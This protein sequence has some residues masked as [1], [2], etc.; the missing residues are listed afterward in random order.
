MADL[1][2]SIKKGGPIG[3]V[4]AIILGSVFAV[5]GGYVNDKDDPGGETNHGITKAVAIKNGYVGP[6]ISMPKETAGEIYYKNY[7][8]GPGFEPMINISPAVT[9]ELVDSGVNM[10][11]P[12]P[13]R[14]F[15]ESLNSLSRGCK[16]YAC[17]AVDG[18][19]GASTIGA[20]QKLQK[21]RGHIQACQLV[22][23][24]LDAKQAVYYMG[25]TNLNKYT[26]GWVANRV[27][28]VPLSKCTNYG[29]VFNAQ[30][31]VPQY[32]YAE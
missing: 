16:D 10:G 14:W 15:Q 25:L 2:T 1:S 12:R 5:E 20:Y 9:E 19:V 18:Q 29:G 31:Q 7:I 17:I 21:A 11:P 13:S 27:G 6:M 3:A 32:T 8:K 28:N 22:I 23:K 26:P 30:V 4:V 24:L